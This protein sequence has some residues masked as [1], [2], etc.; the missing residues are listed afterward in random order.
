[1]LYGTATSFALTLRALPGDSEEPPG[2]AASLQ[3]AV[4]EPLVEGRVRRTPKGRVQFAVFHVSDLSPAWNENCHRDA[5]DF[6]RVAPW[7]IAGDNEF[8]NGTH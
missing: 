4:I 7:L 1:L 2:D 8:L 6:H 3:P 5:L